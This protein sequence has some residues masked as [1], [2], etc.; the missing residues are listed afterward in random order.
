MR[1][2]ELSKVSI[3][4]NRR[5]KDPP[6]SIPSSAIHQMVESGKLD[7]AQVHFSFVTN[8]VAPLREDVFRNVFCHFGLIK[9]IHIKKCQYDPVRLVRIL[10]MQ[11]DSDIVLPLH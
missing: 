6:I 9:D 1:W 2:S 5:K 11:C 10:S 7:R 3:K 4:V 8:K